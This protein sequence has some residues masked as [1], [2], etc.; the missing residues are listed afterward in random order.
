MKN[1]RIFTIIFITIFLLFIQTSCTTQT[2]E[3]IKF[4]PAVVPGFTFEITQ[5]INF[6]SSEFTK[7]GNVVEG[8]FLTNEEIL[9]KLDLLEIAVPDTT[10][11]TFGLNLELLSFI[12]AHDDLDDS[13]DNSR[14]N[15]EIIA[16][17]GAI[18]FD[19]LVFNDAGVYDFQI[20]SDDFELVFDFSVYVYE[21]IENLELVAVVSYKIP[22]VRLLNHQIYFDVTDIIQ[23][24]VV[25]RWNVQIE[26]AYLLGY[27]YIKDKYGD[28]IRQRINV[29]APVDKV[30]PP[31]TGFPEDY[32]TLIDNSHALNYLV[33]VNRHYRL[34][35]TFSPSDLSIVNVPSINGMHSLRNSAARATEDLFNAATL[36][37]HSL[38]ASSGYRSF[39]T[40]YSTHNHWIN[41]HGLER[42]RRASARA[43]HSEHQLG[44]AIDVTSVA[45]GSLSQEFSHTPEGIWIRE[46][47]HLF[48]FI[49]R[50]PYGREEETG[51][52]YEPWHLR[53]IGIESAT[54]LFGSGLILEEFLWGN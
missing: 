34:C 17:V 4:S 54:A 42:A 51:Y 9:D 20:S 21:E 52:M 39:W 45:L 16:E 33:L 22:V 13:F 47:A 38:V 43:G 31:S 25:K 27:R 12:S 7:Q 46:N 50:Y 14:F 18:G 5:E 40:Q 24:E 6:I 23:E 1:N 28:Y 53:F 11:V 26:Q 32:S 44:L 8:S 35:Q 41:V 19:E 48:G 36:A 10:P 49:I 30:P 37:G 15:Q 3:T 29:D 2:T